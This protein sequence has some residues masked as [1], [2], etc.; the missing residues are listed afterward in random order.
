MGIRDYYARLREGR[1]Q[2]QSKRH[3]A[4][5]AVTARRAGT[6]FEGLA[7]AWKWKSPTI[8]VSVGDVAVHVDVMVVQT[9]YVQQVYTQFRACY[10]LGV[11]PGF[12]IYPD[13]KAV[14][15]VKAMGYE[16]V[17]LGGDPEFDD[18]FVV[19]TKDR[20]TTRQLWSEHAKQVML[21]D[22]GGRA[23]IGTRGRAITLVIPEILLEEEPLDAGIDLIGELAS[24]GSDW[25]AVLRGLPNAVWVAPRGPWDD[26]T[27]PSAR[28]E[29]RGI[30]VHVHPVVVGL[31]I[32]TCAA[33]EAQRDMPEFSVTRD[34]EGEPPEDLPD[35]IAGPS[36]LRLISEL[37]EA[38]I[39]HEDRFV[40]ITLKGE[41]SPHRIMTTVELAAELAFGE[42]S[43]GAYR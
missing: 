41:L 33:A 8:D 29:H 1:A 26:R 14:A 18:H 13:S 25:L 32:T 7:K 43:E 34:G 40:R 39:G 38:E 37:G 2:R 20:G 12:K 27:T 3:A 23:H 5:Q 15:L 42:R 19:R 31:G 11:G 24:Y 36:A 16:D 22:L 35:S 28:I 4:W 6:Y 9:Q 21:Q 30:P 10:L 17:V